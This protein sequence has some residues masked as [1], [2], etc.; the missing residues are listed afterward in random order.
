MLWSRSVDLSI[1]REIKT[2]KNF[3]PCALDLGGKSFEVTARPHRIVDDDA[4]F[5]VIVTLLD[6][7]TGR[8]SQLRSQSADLLNRRSN[9]DGGPRQG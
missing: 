4:E 9:R 6:H 5:A 3:L 2:N 7:H 1:G 8:I